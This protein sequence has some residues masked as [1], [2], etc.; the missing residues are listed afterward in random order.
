M[1]TPT[2]KTARPSIRSPSPHGE[3]T[4][5]H[6]LEV[7]G[8]LFADYGY[9]GTTS[10]QVCTAA[11]VNLAGVNYHFGGREGLYA[12]VLVEAHRR[13]LS[14]EALSEIAAGP[15]DARAK[16]C[17][18]ID[19]LIGGMGQEGWHLRVFMRELIAPSPALDTMLLVEVAPKVGIAKALLAQAAGLALDDP[20]LPRC[21]LSTFAPCMMLL[22]ANKTIISRV[23]A[24]F[25][26]DQQA[27]A[28]H[29]KTFALAGLDAIA[30]GD[31]R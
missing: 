13:L 1:D 12:A 27:L 28:L 22:I 29:L 26:Q 7:A 14:R 18:V 15:G 23:M 10:K 11:Q 4:R 5:Q 2:Q 24:D 20:R 25:W 17:L 9:D 31:L 6:I 16:L 21:F 8:L 3:A 30:R 19:R